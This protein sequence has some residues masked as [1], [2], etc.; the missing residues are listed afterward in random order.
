MREGEASLLAAGK[1]LKTGLLSRWK[2]DWEGAAAEYEKAATA[3]RVGRAAP[4]AMDAFVKAAE[5]HQHFD[6]LFMAAKHLESAAMLARDLTQPDSAASLYEKSANLHRLDGRIDA[7]AEAL[8]KAARAVEANDP[9]RAGE[10]MVAACDLFALEGADLTEVQRLASLDTYRAAVGLLLRAKQYKGAAALLRRQALV[11]VAVEQPHGV[12]RC[13]LSV[14]V[15]L[16][17]AGEYEAAADDCEAAQVRGDG[18]GGSEEASAALELLDVMAMQDETALAV[19]V[20]KQ[21]F[22]FLD[23]KITQLAKALTLAAARV[24]AHRIISAPM[25]GGGVAAGGGGGALPPPP[26]PAPG[27]SASASTGDFGE[28]APEDELTEDLT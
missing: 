9:A 18:F 2:P 17:T 27:A 19:C 10:L 15:A 24:P 6:S 13:E 5:A 22:T 26:P 25:A 28:M 4:R 8:S 7:A 16:L 23:N 1:C 3:F 14:V 21:I 20:G 11:H 12:A